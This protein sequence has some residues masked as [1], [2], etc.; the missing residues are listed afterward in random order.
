ML[1]TPVVERGPGTDSTS[2]G[3]SRSYRNHRTVRFVLVA[4]GVGYHIYADVL[5]LA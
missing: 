5:P 1:N 2:R 3:R 4:T